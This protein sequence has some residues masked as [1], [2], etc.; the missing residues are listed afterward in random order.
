MCVCDDVTKSQKSIFIKECK[1]CYE[2][3]SFFELQTEASGITKSD[4]YRKEGI[5]D[6]KV[7]RLLLQGG[8]VIRK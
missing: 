1:C 3:D 6:Y 5:F 2:R 7:G 8:K 4:R